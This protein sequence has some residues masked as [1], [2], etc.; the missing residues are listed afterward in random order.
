MSRDAELKAN[1][2]EVLRLVNTFKKRNILVFDQESVVEGEWYLLEV[3]QGDEVAQWAE[4]PD[5]RRKKEAEEQGYRLTPV[6][7][8]RQ[9]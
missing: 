7:I 1:Y 9:E 3:Q 2:E 5:D 8:F 4:C 6:K